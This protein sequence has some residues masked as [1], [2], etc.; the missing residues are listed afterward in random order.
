MA[1][2]KETAENQD[3]QGSGEP[4]PQQE[5][6]REGDT[7][8]R[9][10]F[11]EQFKEGSEREAQP[12]MSKED[13][14]KFYEESIPF[15]KLQDEYEDLIYR[16]KERTVKTL[17]LEVRHIEAIG[18]LAQWKQGQDEARHREE[19]EKEMKEKWEKMSDE[20]K[21]EHTRKAME[22]LEIMKVQAKGSVT[23]DG[24]N[25]HLVMTLV[26]GEPCT[27]IVV[28]GEDKQFSFQLPQAGGGFR[29]VTMVPGQIISR[30]EKGELVV[31]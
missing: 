23:Y 5:T 25:A 3:L 8:G 1:Q 26:K 21:E 30:T 4:V 22:N 6:T 11:K 20:E 18:Y 19:Q 28:E 13:T 7:I 12:R 15:M 2:E 24:N 10:S 14:I 31:L 29:E 16:H 27:S 17:E 9:N